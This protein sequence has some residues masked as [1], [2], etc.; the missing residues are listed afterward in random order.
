MDWLTE[1][2]GRMTDG[3][4]YTAAF[5]GTVITS[6]AV[7]VKGV[8]PATPLATS[9]AHD[10]HGIL[11]FNTAKSVS[12][13]DYLVDIAL[14][15]AAAERVVIPNLLFSAGSS[16]GVL[17]SFYLPLNVPKGSRL[18]ARA[19]CST[20]SGTIT[21]GC[22]VVQGTMMGLSSFD[23]FAAHGALTATSGGTVLA[24]PA[25]A[26]WGAWTELDAAVA[27]D[28]EWLMLVGGD[29]KIA[30]RTAAQLHAWQA[31]VGAATA[32]VALTAPLTSGGSSTSL[33]GGLVTGAPYQV[34]AGQRLA[35]RYGS[36]AITTLGLAA[37][38]YAG[39]T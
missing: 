21:L 1:G 5:V 3:V 34:K 9:T 29:N 20:A 2:V 11:I 32:E 27:E 7:N 14:G 12:A 36:S 31:G 4:G 25:A 38:A 8:Y 28:I 13:G 10:S 19:Q 22:A 16:S 24:N 35:A 23:R 37:V 17:R 26:G 15:A 33:G 18:N 39:V 30:T 6:G